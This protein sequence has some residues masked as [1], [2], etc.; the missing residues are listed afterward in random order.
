[1]KRSSSTSSG[2]SPGASQATLTD[3]ASIGRSASMKEV[4]TISNDLRVGRASPLYISSSTNVR[5]NRS[6]NYSKRRYSMNEQDATQPEK[7]TKLNNNEIIDL[8]EREQDAIVLKLMKEIEYLKEENRALKSSMN[9]ATRRKSSL[10]SSKSLTSSPICAYTPVISNSGRNFG[11]NSGRYTTATTA[12][13]YSEG[14]NQSHDSSLFNSNYSNEEHIPK[15]SYIEGRR[16]AK[17]LDN[18]LL[19]AIEFESSVK[20]S[21]QFLKP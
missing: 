13:S 14:S 21:G 8:M 5:N 17:L 20:D 12:R 18:T 16:Q 2:T 10:G 4:S 15:E 1:M 9:A 19:P 11:T 3:G 7:Q 6:P